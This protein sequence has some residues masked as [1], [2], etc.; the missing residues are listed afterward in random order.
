MEDAMVK[1]AEMKPSVWPNPH[2]YMPFVNNA[3]SNMLL[4]IA[5]VPIERRAKMALGVALRNAEN[6][7]DNSEKR[8]AAQITSDRTTEPLP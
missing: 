5:R 7:S 8:P 6:S 1:K 3:P 2:W 4:I